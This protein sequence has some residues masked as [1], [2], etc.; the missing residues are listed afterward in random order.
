M[1]MRVTAP[2]RIDLAGGTTDLYPLFLLM[3]GGCTVN[4]AVTVGSRVTFRSRNEP[5]LKISS[6]DLGESV[7]G[8]AAPDLPL[9][10]PLALLCRAAKVVPPPYPVEITTLNQAP[11]GSGL[12]ASSALLVAAL[13]GLLRLRNEEPAPEQ[14][15]ELACNVETAVIGVP[16]GKQDYIAAFYG[17]ISLI[18]FGYRGFARRTVSW[19]P[20]VWERLQEMLVLTYTGEGRFSGLTNWDMTKAFIDDRHNVRDK[21]LRIRDVA[22]SV[23]AI[24]LE[25]DL[26]E[27]APLIDEEWRLRK[28]LAPGVSTPRIESI[29][30][31]AKDAGAPASKICGAGGG[32]CMVTIVP[33][34]KR[35]TVETA[36]T[37][38]GG[39]II[40]FTIDQGGAVVRGPGA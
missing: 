14:F 11:A 12:G 15:I 6:E 18:E 2:N 7:E 24:L 21:L 27:L 26:H 1:E 20:P 16:A 35:K 25:G 28:T 36:V 30:A 40:P 13:T 32:G 9:T 10:G 22:R 34:E 38:A 29:M 4:V 3:E 5:G 39:T 23:G 17:G 37:R 8:P 19:Q 31:A 33:P